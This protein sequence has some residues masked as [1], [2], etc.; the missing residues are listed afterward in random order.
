MGRI[1]LWNPVKGADYLFVDQTIGE[2]F[3]ISG[4]AVL[5]HMYEGPTTDAQ[6]NP[7]PGIG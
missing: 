3:R 7:N 1:S 5:V 6:G 4:D 2:N